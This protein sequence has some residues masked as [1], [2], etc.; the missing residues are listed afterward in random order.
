MAEKY[1]VDTAPPIRNN[2]R[3]LESSALAVLVN[4]IVLKSDVLNH[5]FM[6]DVL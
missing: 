4:V 5:A 1:S 2:L 6:G 3:S